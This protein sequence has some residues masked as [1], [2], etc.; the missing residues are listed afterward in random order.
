MQAWRYGASLDQFP[1]LPRAAPELALAGISQ[2]TSPELSYLR[3]LME[4]APKE[5]W[6][7]LCAK[8][9]VEKDPHKLLELVTEINRLLENGDRR[10]LSRKPSDDSSNG[11]RHLER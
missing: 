4:D 7:E 11:S 9:A 2:N 3:C 8:A 6:R 1:I 5:R 10:A